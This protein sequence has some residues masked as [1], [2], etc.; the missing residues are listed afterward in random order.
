M[1][2][3]SKN[4][5][6]IYSWQ[7][8]V[9]LLL[10][11]RSVNI[12]SVKWLVVCMQGGRGTSQWRP[13]R[14]RSQRRGIVAMKSRCKT[15]MNSKSRSMESELPP[16]CDN[17]S[18]FPRHMKPVWLHFV[19]PRFGIVSFF[20]NQVFFPPYQW[21]LV[22]N[23]A[24]SCILVN[25]L[26]YKLKGHGF[27]TQWGDIFSIYLILLAALGPGAHSVSEMSIRNR[28]ITMFLGS[29]VR[30]VCRV[31]NLVAICEPTV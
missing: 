22:H 25:A 17:I 23:R 2:Y 3:T 19:Q 11:I 26:C 7:R 8:G 21:I 29:K 13:D 24:C 10:I 9:K 30:P 31:D 15:F 28:K 16:T 14:A 1:E 18:Q 12:I 6:T 27:E 4:T 5:L 20:H